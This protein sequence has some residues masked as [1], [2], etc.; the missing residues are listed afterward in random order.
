M[1]ASAAISLTV[2]RLK[3]ARGAKA[4]TEEKT[5][6]WGCQEGVGRRPQQVAAVGALLLGPIPAPPPGTSPGTAVPFACRWIAP[7]VCPGDRTGNY[8]VCLR[9]PTP[10]RK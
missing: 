8:S 4:P 3:Q 1:I 6:A 7:P 10:D 5:A 9:Y 2:V